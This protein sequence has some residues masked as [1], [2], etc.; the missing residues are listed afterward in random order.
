MHAQGNG[1]F[2]EIKV[3]YVLRSDMS[4]FSALES[5][6]GDRGMT[7]DEFGAWLADNTAMHV[8]TDERFDP[9]PAFPLGSARIMV[10][11]VNERGIVDENSMTVKISDR[12]A[13][14]GRSV[15]GAQLG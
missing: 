11:A 10:F 12:E 7:P 3:T 6:V 14:L 2:E 8:E 15:N 9:G 13:L 4:G 1:A 5:R